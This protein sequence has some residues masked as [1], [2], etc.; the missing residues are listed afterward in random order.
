MIS[1]FFVHSFYFLNWV[2]ILC[3]RFLLKLCV[4]QNS[5]DLRELSQFVHVSVSITVHACIHLLTKSPGYHCFPE[6]SRDS[7]WPPATSSVW[8]A[9]WRA[10]Q[11]SLMD[12]LGAPRL[13]LLIHS[14]TLHW[15]YCYGNEWTGLR[16]TALITRDHT[17]EWVDRLSCCAQRTA[18]VDFTGDNT[19]CEQA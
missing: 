7:H 9:L 13:R 14:S 6:S 1:V 10:G 12:H 19:V 3:V 17:A 11:C 16:P 4:S 5:A 18:T 15:A 8:V 2:K